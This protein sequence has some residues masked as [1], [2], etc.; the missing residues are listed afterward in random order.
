MKKLRCQILFADSYLADYIPPPDCTDGSITLEPTIYKEGAG[1]SEAGVFEAI[2]VN[3][4]FP[5]VI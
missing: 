5:E 3:A 2:A 1:E 4:L